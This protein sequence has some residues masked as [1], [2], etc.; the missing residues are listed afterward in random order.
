M[1]TGLN[2]KNNALADAIIEGNSDLAKRLIAQSP[3]LI[4]AADANGYTPLIFAAI[5]RNREIV[6]LLLAKGA[7]IRAQAGDGS[8]ALIEAIRNE[9]EEMAKLLIESG[10][11]LNERGK[12]RYPPLAFAVIC[13]SAEIVQRLLDAGADING[14]DS[15]GN[16]GVD[17]ARKRGL[18]H[19]E[20]LIVA[21]EKQRAKQAAQRADEERKDKNHAVAETRQEALKKRKPTIRFNP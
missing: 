6:S 13:E 9:D 10:A 8:T 21:A 11:E 1:Q 4:N 5:E 3:T 14:T 15:A 20:S 18:D 17:W 7:K 19:M 2:V 16:T 12:H